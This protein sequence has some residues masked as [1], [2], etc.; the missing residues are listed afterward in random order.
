MT[1]TE[2]IT[3][4]FQ[5]DH[6]RLDGL[7]QQFRA[8]KQSDPAKAKELFLQ[9]RDGLLRHIRWEEDLLFPVF[10]S[11][12]GLH[13]SGPTAVMRFEHEQI[14]KALSRISEQMELGGSGLD[15]A[16][17]MLIAVLVEHNM[18]E[19]VMLYPTMDEIVSDEEREGIFRKMDLM[20]GHEGGGHCC[21]QHP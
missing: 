20:T 2:N 9:F 16:E 3:S 21:E 19:E 14:Q 12:T 1:T 17:Q 10:E 5:K 6:H 15:D 8:L 13:G 11:K 4:F 7:F 18:K